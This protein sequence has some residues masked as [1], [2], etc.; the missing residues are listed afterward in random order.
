MPFVFH[1]VK[2]GK[3]GNQA[4]PGGDLRLL[5]IHFVNRH[6]LT[7]F[8]TP[9]FY[10]LASDAFDAYDDALLRDRSDRFDRFDRLIDLTDLNC[11]AEYL[12]DLTGLTDL[13]TYSLSVLLI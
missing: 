4:F 11:I 13:L 7:Q 3:K 1:S 12:P 2:K 10:I 8:S 6:K 5:L 9:L